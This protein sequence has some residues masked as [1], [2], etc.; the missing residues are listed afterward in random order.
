MLGF[1]KRLFSSKGDEELRNIIKDGAFLVDVRTPGEF[2]SG[3]VKGS[4]NIP[5]SQVKSQIN[6]FKGKKNIVVFCKSGGRSMQ[7]KSI[8]EKSGFEN[9]INGRTWTTVNHLLNS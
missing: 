4:V 6:K 8:L 9:V 7:A 1:F 5:L 2:A 3:N